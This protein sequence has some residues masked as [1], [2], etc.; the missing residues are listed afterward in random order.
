[1]NG[2]TIGFLKEVIETFKTDNN[3]S[4]IDRYNTER[5][6][7]PTSMNGENKNKKVF[8]YMLIMPD[9]GININELLILDPMT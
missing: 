4:G 6:F 9:M 7:K 1:M 3:I 8:F 5:T 2:W